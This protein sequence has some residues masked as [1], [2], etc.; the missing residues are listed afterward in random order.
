MDNISIVL[1]NPVLVRL[2]KISIAL[3]ILL[4]SLALG[5]FITQSDGA[6]TPGGTYATFSGPTGAN[7]S[8]TSSVA[9]PGANGFP[10]ASLATNSLTPSV[11]SGSSTWLSPSTPFGGQFASS[12]NQPYFVFSPT[13]GQAPS[14]TTIT[15]ATPTPA[16]GWGFALGD[17]D[18]EKIQ[19]S[20]TDVNGA[21]VA[22]SG[23]GFQSVFNFCDIATTKPS[24][25][26]GV[27]APFDTPTW[28]AS[29]GWLTGGVNDSVGASGWFMPSA[30]IKTLT[31]ID[32]NQSG[33]PSA[34]L[35]ISSNLRT[36][37]GNISE[38]P[39][40]VSVTTTTPATTT[41][42]EP[43]TTTST[44]TT[45]TTT[46]P[47]TTTVPMTAPAGNVPAVDVPV[48]ITD[49]SGTVVDT[50]T[51]DANGNFAMTTIAPGKY[52]LS[53]ELPAGY[54]APTGTYPL[55]ID[56]TTGDVTGI[57]FT[58]VPKPTLAFS[59]ANVAVLGGL[60]M[61]LILLGGLV[62]R[63]QLRQRRQI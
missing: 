48:Q 54:S 25:C 61:M 6:T 26:S 41:T 49:L 32:A 4:S 47:T 23:L 59:G 55:P 39:L 22:I 43:P 2:S 21:A 13:T 51:T 19:I 17:V 30:P 60:G 56:V 50:T 38:P 9:I 62:L 24:T 11:P 35:W 28:D 8:W 58:N 33:V 29:S 45:T 40:A 57:S 36:V 14:T 20:A 44:S 53:E 5:L 46:E 1:F 12:Q 52:L 27:T 42:T 34:Q 15:F 18:A 63:L 37:A 31:L 3:G 10:T 7:P 16:A